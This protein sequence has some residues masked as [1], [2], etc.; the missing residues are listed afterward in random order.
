MLLSNFCILAT[1]QVK[2]ITLVV[3]SAKNKGDRTRPVKFLFLKKIQDNSQINDSFTT[4]C[5]CLTFFLDLRSCDLKRPH[6]TN[7]SD[8]TN[9]SKP[10]YRPLDVCFSSSW[11]RFFINGI[12]S[13]LC[14]SFKPW[15]EVVLMFQVAAILR[16]G[17]G[18]R[19]SSGKNENKTKQKQKQIKHS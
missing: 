5:V 3:C 18:G 19:P 10:P 9:F 12:I 11:W 13:M 17:R 6:Q 4:P 14:S 16:V 7:I 8:N 1:A 15:P 2:I